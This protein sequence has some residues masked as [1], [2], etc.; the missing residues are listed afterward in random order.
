MSELTNDASGPTPPPGKSWEALSKDLQWRIIS[1]DCR[2]RQRLIED[3]V[4]ERTG[5]TRHAVRRAFDEFEHI[6]LVVRQ[7]NRGIQVR[8]YSIQE[9][10]ELYEIRTCLEVQAATRFRMPAREATLNELTEIAT[11]HRQASREERFAEV[12]TLNNRF[13]ETLYN[14]AGNRLL[15]EAIL[16]Y[17]FATH[18]IRTRA[19]PNEELREIAISDHFE[20]IDA[21]ANRENATLANLVRA[22]IQRPK[23][24]YIKATFVNANF[25]RS[26]MGSD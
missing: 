10:E 21:I 26:A 7:P 5:A 12:F 15:A 13:H 3:D 18:P 23:N 16:R 22:H 9:I 6:G 20:M 24:F 14:A 11:L 25:A 1:G 2:P 17:T 19:F 4:I 8:D